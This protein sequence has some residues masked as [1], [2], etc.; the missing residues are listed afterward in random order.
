M[1]GVIKV[2]IDGE[3]IL[4][5]SFFLDQV[6]P[7]T[8]G[9]TGST[10]A[11]SVTQYVSDWTF[12]STF[13]VKTESKWTVQSST[14]QNDRLSLQFAGAANL[15]LTPPN[16]VLTLNVPR[17]RLP[18]NVLSIGGVVHKTSF[19]ADKGFSTKFGYEHFSR[20]DSTC[21]FADR[22]EG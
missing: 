10:S 14:Y 22:N 21:Y 16:S 11:T 20:N 13:D 9:F 15:S 12:K 6:E 17:M 1:P 4:A 7:Y 19:A 8:I 5:A 3:L 2:L 18:S